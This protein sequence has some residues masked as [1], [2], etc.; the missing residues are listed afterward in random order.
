M[1]I[2]HF[3]YTLWEQDHI[4]CQNSD[5]DKSEREFIVAFFLENTDNRNVKDSD[6]SLIQNE[7]RNIK[8]FINNKPE[9][10]PVLFEAS[11]KQRLKTICCKVQAEN[12]TEALSKAYNPIAR[13]LSFWAVTENSTTSIWALSV[14]DKKYKANWEAK[15]QVAQAFNFKLPQGIS[16]DKK[17]NA[18]F[19]LY[20]EGRTSRSPYYRFFCFAKIL[21]SFYAKGEIFK[22]ANKILEDNGENAMKIRGEK[23]IDKNQ[24]LYAFAIPK[25]KELEGIKYGKFWEWIR[26]NYRHLVG[27]AFPDKY[28]EEQW[29]DLDEFQ[30]FTD[31]A[32]ICNI[33]DL[34]VRDLII[35]ELD[36]YQN[37]VEKGYIKIPKEETQ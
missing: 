37:M 3:G 30:N 32:I 4:N 12:R 13:T 14:T 9:N 19:S 24:L 7:S 35:S 34:V 17:F 23:K 27:H 22:G 5:K 28:D 31:F 10:I 8:I 2:P 33:V 16:F 11:D 18:V 25:H 1:W 29:L 6:I 21:E 20:R 15:P 36:L 26:A